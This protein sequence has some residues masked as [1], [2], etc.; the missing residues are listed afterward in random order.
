M[1]TIQATGT[2]V[3]SFDVVP[4][5]ADGDHY[6]IPDDMTGEWVHT[7]PKVHEDLATRANKGFSDQWKPLVKMIKKW[8]QV[9]GHP[10]EPS[11]LIEVMALSLITGPWSGNHARELRQF[12]ASAGAQIAEGWPDPAGVGPN[13]SDVLDGDSA[14]MT[15]ARNA[16]RGAEATCTAAINTDRAGRTGDALVAWRGLFGSLFPLS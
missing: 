3:L 13:V 15:V 16:L 4:A 14:K 2:K 12:F 9:R 5:F 8:N 11:F 10:I 6:L 7:N 1:R